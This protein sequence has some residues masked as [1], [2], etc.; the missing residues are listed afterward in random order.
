MMFG[1]SK[2]DISFMPPAEYSDRF[3]EFMETKVSIELY[4]CRLL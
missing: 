4:M 2:E 1:A 3:M